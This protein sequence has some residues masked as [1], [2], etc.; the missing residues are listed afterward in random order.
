M[1]L[2]HIPRKSTSQRINKLSLNTQGGVVKK[3][4]FFIMFCIFSHKT[5]QVQSLCDLFNQLHAMQCALLV[6]ML[7]MF[8][9]KG[10]QN[11]KEHFCHQHKH[12]LKLVTC[13]Y[14]ALF[15]LG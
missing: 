9:T 3:H 7:I 1:I 4:T 14:A 13:H 10:K 15:V 12:T 6:T 11:Q 8:N 2:K 5:S